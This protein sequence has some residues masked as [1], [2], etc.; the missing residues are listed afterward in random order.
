LL[1]YLGQAA[2][3][4]L[5]IAYLSPGRP[6]VAKELRRL[7]P[8]TVE[9]TLAALAL[10]VPLGLLA[11]LL[12]AAY[13][14]GWPD[15]LAIA[16]SSL[17][18]SVPI[19]FLGIVLL[20]AFPGMPGSGRLD[21]RLSMRGVESTGLF[22]V[23]ALVAGRW[24]LWSSA[25]RHLVLPAATLA[26]VPVALV[27]RVTRASLLEVLS[28]DFVRTARAKGGSRG[29]VLLFHA[30]PAAAAPILS[31]LGLQLASLLAGAVLTE[32]VFTWPGLGR[33]VMLAA[34]RKD[35]NA[36]QGAVLLLGVVFIAVN[37]LTDIV[38]MLIDPR[39][40]R[41]GGATS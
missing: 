21:V 5:G 10:A 17:G 2:R 30:L 18:V 20:L 23:D 28:S 15:R 33:Y 40:R 13:R 14:G 29:R 32:T 34:S 27:A 37:A 3:G 7:F 26:T 35:Y 22:L 41:R 39:L 25:F 11:G 4:D 12:A 31:L 19:F 8:A 16:V 1:G 9:L 36:L 38:S 24:D 6:S